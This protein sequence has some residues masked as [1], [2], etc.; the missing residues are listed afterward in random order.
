MK[1]AMHATKLVVR[2]VEAA[3]RFYCALGMTVVNRNTGGE[4]EVHQQQSWLSSTGAEGE[5]I[6]ILTK[7]LELP[8]PKD[9]SYPGE[10]W[11]CFM[12]EDVEATCAT[13]EAG[14]GHV[15]RAGEDRPEHSVRAAVVADNEG[16]FIE[17]VGPM[18][19]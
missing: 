9:P 19:V 16:H 13:V 15:V 6:L 7:F 12:V 17:L 18:K 4:K 11:L 1:F 14:G 3:E 2:D 10:I 8:E 5:H